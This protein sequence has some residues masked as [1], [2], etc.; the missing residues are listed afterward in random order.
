MFMTTSYTAGRS[1]HASIKDIH[2]VPVAD[3][4]LQTQDVSHN[5]NFLASRTQRGRQHFASERVSIDNF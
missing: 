5:S 3:S 2:F 4:L 1:K